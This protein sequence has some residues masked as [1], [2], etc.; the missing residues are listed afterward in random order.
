MYQLL[1]IDS[2]P[3]ISSQPCAIPCSITNSTRPP[4]CGPS[5]ISIP[6]G[7]MM[8]VPWGVARALAGQH[9]RLLLRLFP[10]ESGARSGW[11]SGSPGSRT[12]ATNGT[13]GS[14][15]CPGG[16]SPNDQSSADSSCTENISPISETRAS[17]WLSLAWKSGSNFR[18]SMCA[19]RADLT[20]WATGML[21]IS[22]SASTLA[23]SSGS[24]RKVM[25]FVDF[26]TSANQRPPSAGPVHLSS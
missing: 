21:S 26:S 20:T 3:R 13:Q 10:T 5:S 24:K 4:S 2:S 19:L 7:G 17:C 18:R 23:A 16:R 22:A 14:P 11:L 25:F 1:R 8:F 9:R 12:E 15:R 6:T